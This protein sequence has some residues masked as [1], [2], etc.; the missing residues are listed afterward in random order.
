MSET[1]WLAQPLFLVP[2]VA[3][4]GALV[5]SFLNV[6]ILRLPRRLEHDWRQQAHDVLGKEVPA[7][8]T[9]PDLVFTASHCPHCKHRL[10]A[11]DNIPLLGWLDD[12]VVA[13][14]LLQL[15]FKF[16]PPALMGALRSKV[17]ARVRPRGG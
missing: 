7:E 11:R 10:G 8:D 14:L 6:V 17:D 9:P 2:L 4:L 5:G 16:V 15:A 12:G 1:P 3:L 13:Y